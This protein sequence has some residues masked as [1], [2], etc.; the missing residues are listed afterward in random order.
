MSEQRAQFHLLAK[1]TGAVCNLDCKYCFFLSKEA[2]YPGSRFRMNDELLENYIRQ[3]FESHGPGEV[4]VAWQGGEPTLMGVEFFRK[5][6][7]LA[8]RYRKPGQTVIHTMQTNGTLIN[9]EWAEFFRE[10]DFLI[11]LSVDGP[12]EIH[13]MYRT[14]KGGGGSFDQV[15]RGWEHLLKHKVEFNILCTLH[16]GNAPYPLEIYRFFRDDLHAQH[17]QFIPIIERATQSTLEIANEG[18]SEKPGG[19]RPLYVQEGDLVTDRSLKA[20]QYGNFLTEIFREWVRRDVGKVFVQMFDVTLASHFDIHSLCIH[21]PVCGSALAMEHNGDMYSCDHFVEPDYLLG[22]ISR[23]SMSELVASEAQMKFG[24]DKLETLPKYCIDCDVRYVC[25]GGCPKDRFITAPD[26]EPGLNYLCQGYKCFF[27]MTEHPVKIMA[28][29]IRVGRY[30][31]EI[32]GI[33]NTEEE[34]MKNLF[35]NA[36]RNELC[37]CGSKKKKKHCHPFSYP[38]VEEFLTGVSPAEIVSRNP[39]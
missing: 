37:P 26:G 12:R 11:G 8:G 16:S 28:E 34:R 10:N 35:R 38:E 36:E 13:D 5:S 17:I 30:A 25:N 22:N 24:E 32:M 15:M 4:N 31:D 29:L 6:V 21:A 9:D 14:N 27:G 2:L 18:W 3:L 19:E 39:A 20:D 23:S 33:Y 7:E 1:P